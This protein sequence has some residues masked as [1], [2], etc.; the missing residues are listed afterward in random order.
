MQIIGRDDIGRDRINHV[1]EGAEQDAVF[2]EDVIQAG[3][4]PG[5][6]PGI[7]RSK[8]Y[9]R[10][11]S[12]HAH[13]L[14]T[15]MISKRGQPFAVDALDCCDTIEDRL[16]FKNLQTGNRRGTAQRIS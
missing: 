15:W 1:T 12:Q 4:K 5:K 2:D 13:I 10:D 14:N 16:G 9:C 6:V 7:V 11:R 8:L 3:A